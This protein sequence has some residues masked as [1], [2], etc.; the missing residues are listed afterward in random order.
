MG[1]PCDLHLYGK[2]SAVHQAIDQAKA[3]VARLESKYSRYRS[4]SYL[5]RINSQGG[6]VQEVDA[7]TAGLLDFAEQCYQQSRGLFDLT[8]GVLRSVWSFR[9]R[10]LPDHQALQACLERVGWHR[11]AWR[12]PCLVL[13]EG[14]ELD[15]GG[16]VKEFAADRV[17][18]VLYQNEVKGLVNLAGDIRV[19]GLQP[20]GMAWPVGI[21][22][23]RQP[24]KVVAWIPLT[25]G[26]LATSGD[27]ERFFELDGRRYCH[28]LSPK[29][30]YPLEQAPASVSVLAD[31][32]LLAG[33]LA[34]MAMLMGKD[35]ESWL[36]SLGVPFLLFDQTLTVHGTFN[37]RLTREVL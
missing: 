2:P 11:L 15:L 3:E 1:G 34:T 17:L 25:E 29:T 14:M 5:N 33:A 4:D 28:I 23:P 18:A 6:Q 37:E 36:A 31:N 32:C 26:A 22:H 16:V 9:D 24:D 13:P 19:T 7:E 10:R 27:Y 8:T 30:G 20:D 12:N 21:R 35:A